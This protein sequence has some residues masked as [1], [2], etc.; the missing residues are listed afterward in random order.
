MISAPHLHAGPT[1]RRMMLSVLLCLLPAGFGAVVRY[2]P[3]ALYVLLAAIGA[4][5]LTELAIAGLA[6]R[7]F[8]LGDGSA[9]LTG[10]LIGLTLPPAVPLYVPIAAAVF[11]IA[12]VKMTFGG[13]G[14]NWMN[15]ALG[16]RVFVMFSWP[17]FFHASPAAGR[18]DSLLCWVWNGTPGAIGEVSAALL[19][20][21]SVYLFARRIIRWEIPAAFI[22]SFSL[23]VW[24]FAGLPH[25]FFRGDLPLYL[26]TGGLLLGALYQATDPVTSPLT[27]T[28]RLI[29]GAGCGLLAFLVR[30][31][32]SYPEGV[33]PA[34]V[35]MNMLVP[36]INRLTRRA[37]C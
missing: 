22:G 34:V 15:P 17:V 30:R 23:A 1:S 7:R 18:A 33:A 24:V 3:P 25:G 5:L 26:L 13:L 28:G 29:F 35:F 27:R 37:A 6:F 8:T 10:L 36:L 11:A 21:G 32:G 16:G 4:S 12:V 9:A 20:L 2:G 31:F 14:R 19:V